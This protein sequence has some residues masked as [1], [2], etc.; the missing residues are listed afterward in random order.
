M[1][2]YPGDLLYILNYQ[3]ESR[4]KGS[5]FII[6]YL[7]K[8]YILEPEREYNT[9]IIVRTRMFEAVK[10]N[11]SYSKGVEYYGKPDDYWELIINVT[12]QLNF[13]GYLN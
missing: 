13:L 10:L 11:D 1:P 9:D 4:K 6:P 8:E 2:F 7:G 5:F 3:N 12:R